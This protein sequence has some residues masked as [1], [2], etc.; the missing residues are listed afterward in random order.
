[1][2][3][4]TGAVEWAEEEAALA[5]FRAATSGGQI[6]TEYKKIALRWEQLAEGYR[7][8]ERISGFIQWASQNVPVP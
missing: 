6:S 3:R 5:H 7:E 4:I 8:A 2:K 1:M